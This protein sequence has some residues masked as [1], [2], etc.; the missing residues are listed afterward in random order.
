MKLAAVFA[1]PLLVALSGT[2]SAV[3]IDFETPSS[4]ASVGQHYDGGTDSDGVVGLDLGVGFGLDVLALRNDAAGPYFSNAP[5]PIGVMT[6]VGP[7]AVMNVSGGFFQISL[8]YSSSAAVSNAVSF[9]SNSNGGGTMLGSFSLVNNAQT[10]C[11]D[12]AYCNFNLLT[13]SLGTRAYSATFGNAA[14]VAA[15]DNISVAVPE[16]ATMLLSALGLAAV[17]TVA[18]RRR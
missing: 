2:A 15:F 17:V 11:S 4:F 8:S 7:D 10:G 13:A 16:P 5:S 1:L 12:T 3:T 18:R 9:W 14:N 6:V